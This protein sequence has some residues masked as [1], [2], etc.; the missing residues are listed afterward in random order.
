LDILLCTHE[1]FLPLSGGCTIGNLRIAQGLAARGH[2]VRVLS[3]LQLSQAEAAQEAPGVECRRFEPWRMH[4]SIP[5]R[6]P[7]YL[8]YSA[9]YAFALW[10]EVSRR[11]PQVLLL[12]NAVLG[13]P[14]LLVA[15]LRRIPCA[16]SYTDL[17]STLLGSDRKF[18]R[19]L[20]WAL[21]QY[22]V[23]L[24]AHF[25]A[26]MSI[27]T[28]IQQALGAG[29]VTLDGADV[30]LFKPLAARSRSALR[31]Q[32]GVGPRETLVAFHGTV[33]AHHGQQLMPRIVA[34]APE[35]RFLIVA[36]GPGFPAL[37]QAM[38]G[39]K[40][41]VVL[42]FQKPAAV[43]R[44]VACAD[45]G[46]VPYEPNEG[47]DLV[48]TLKLLEYFA[49]GLPVTCFRLKSAQDTFGKT[50][51]LRPSGGLEDFVDHLRACAGL[52]PSASLRRRIRAEFSWDS[53]TGRMA[54]VLEGL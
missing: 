9:L 34:A 12:R 8:C 36:G 15:K 50:P 32:L 40:N 54:A 43:A 4:R 27:S 42:P 14:V 10:R 18:P 33:E 30:D 17:L 13:I 22:E 20:I 51:Y 41:A 53:V 19:L 3:P 21:R 48:F 45:V 49:L 31:R 24:G 38:R 44:L 52:R 35:L 28:G 29:T 39:L 16:I 11:P 47:L 7:K 25:D 37:G 5:L 2:R 6:F 46:M 1:P 26:V 23:R